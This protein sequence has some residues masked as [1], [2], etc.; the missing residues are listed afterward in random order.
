MKKQQHSPKG[1]GQIK[2]L[3]KRKLFTEP[4]INNINKEKNWQILYNGVANI[5]TR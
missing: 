2:I 3:S 1:N 5:I 4:W